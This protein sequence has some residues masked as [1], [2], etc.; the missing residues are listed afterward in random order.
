MMPQLSTLRRALGVLALLLASACGDA[1]PPP[2]LPQ[3]PAADA[4]DSLREEVARLGATLDAVSES[5]DRVRAA[6]GEPEGVSLAEAGETARSYGL[7]AFFALLILAVTAGL[8]R[9]AVRILDSLSERTAER[10][11]FFKRLVPMV[12]IIAWAVAFTFVVR[13]ILDVDAQGLLAAAAAIGVAVG[14]AAQ[15]ILKN[16]FGGL[17]IV[18]D[19][20]FQV[21]DRIG[22]GGTY[23]EVVSIGLRS[24]R[25]VTPDDSLVTVPNAQIVDGQVSNAN[26]GALDCQVVTD[27][28]LPG[29]VDEAL[30]RRV[31]HQVAASSKFVHLHKPI[32]VL[33]R[34]EFRETFLTHLKVKAYVIDARHEFRFMSDV[35]ERARAEFRR[36]GLIGPQHGTRATVD[37]SPWGRADVAHG[38]TAQETTGT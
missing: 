35:T 21:G 28:Y 14:F 6:A 30:A 13:V 8:V 11:L 33:V 31:A 26:T 29:W 37:M 4:R 1:A 22:V 16:I 32:V 27:L 10:R 12:R 9:F 7:R 15:D 25:I 17:V 38:A 5:L 20:P 2:A 23:G 18:F 24:T 19:Q 36:L 3:E 34:D